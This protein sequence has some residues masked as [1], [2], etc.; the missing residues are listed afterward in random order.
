MIEALCTY[1]R[2]GDQMSGQFD[3]GKIAFAQCLLQVVVAHPDHGWPTRCWDGVWRDGAWGRDHR[4]NSRRLLLLRRRHRWR[5]FFFCL[6]ASPSVCVSL[7]IFHFRDWSCFFFLLACL[8]SLLAAYTEIAVILNAIASKIYAWIR[9][10][11]ILTSLDATRR[12]ESKAG[13]NE[14]IFFFLSLKF[15]FLVFH[16][17]VWGRPRCRFS[18]I[19]S[20]RLHDF[21]A[22]YATSLTDRTF[23]RPQ[24]HF[25][26]LF[27]CLFFFVTEEE[28]E[29][30]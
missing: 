15:F 11:A 24:I 7:L 23:F 2:I 12:D 20:S 18:C 4:I 13:K 29:V 19:F 10:V 17:S 5:H 6:A 14:S 21:L 16:L 25:S 1:L 30:R 3:D 22:F 28:A 26:S 8:C 27:C 9:G